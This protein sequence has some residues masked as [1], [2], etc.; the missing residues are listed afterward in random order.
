SIGDTVHVGPALKFP[1]IP[2]F[3]PELFAFLENREPSKYKHFHKG[4]SALQEE[5]AIQILW[6][7]EAETRYPIIAAVGPLQFDVVQFRLQSEYNV[8]TYLNPV[9][10][11]HALWVEDGW[12][13]LNA[14]NRERCSFMV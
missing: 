10:I 1:G 8:T 2:S 14:A 3:A 9:E 4:I 5:G 12:P 6:L 13:A 7:T 11:K